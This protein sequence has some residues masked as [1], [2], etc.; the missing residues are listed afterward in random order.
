MGSCLMVVVCAKHLLVPIIPMNYLVDIFNNDKPLTPTHKQYMTM[1]NGWIRES[2]DRNKFCFDEND[3]RTCYITSDGDAFGNPLNDKI[4]MLRVKTCRVQHNNVAHAIGVRVKDLY[5]SELNETCH[6]GPETSIYG[7]AIMSLLQDWSP[8][9]RQLY[10]NSL[11]A[12]HKHLQLLQ[13]HHLFPDISDWM[14]DDVP[15]FAKVF[16]IRDHTQ[17]VISYAL[18]LNMWGLLLMVAMGATTLH[19]H[20]VSDISRT[21]IKD[22][23]EKTP[24]AAT[25]GNVLLVRSFQLHTTS[26]QRIIVSNKNR[27]RHFPRPVGDLSFATTGVFTYAKNVDMYMPEDVMHCGFLFSLAK[28]LCCSI[29]ELPGRV[30]PSDYEVI[31]DTHYAVWN[32]L[33]KRN[34]CLRVNHNVRTVNLY[35]IETCEGFMWNYDEWADELRKLDF[36]MLPMIFRSCACVKQEDNTLGLIVP[37]DDTGGNYNPDEGEYRYFTSESRVTTRISAMK[38]LELLV[39]VGTELY[40]DL[41]SPSGSLLGEKV[42]RAQTHLQYLVVRL[43][44]PSVLQA[45]VEKVYVT[46]LQKPTKANANVGTFSS[47]T[48]TV[49]VWELVTVLPPETEFVSALL[50]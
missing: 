50:M 18:G 14:E 2:S 22:I 33:S 36:I 26:P 20:V 43:N 48:I 4:C 47:M 31:S 45:E 49:N 29:F 39:P 19:P 15:A 42:P 17:E 7:N 6:M 25:P 13:L 23:L 44:T 3:K 12:S 11:Y 34:G 28:T 5:G 9:F 41:S 30:V 27:P 46:Y 24:V 16:P 10:G 40:L 37:W 38:T 1:I 32:C 21:L 8:D 35:V